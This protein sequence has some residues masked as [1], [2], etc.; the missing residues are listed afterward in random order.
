[1]AQQK[2]ITLPSTQNIQLREPNLKDGLLVHQLIERC[3]PLDPNSSYCNFLQSGHFSET[4]AAAEKEGQLVG[5]T[6]GYLLPNQP[7]TL[8]FWQVAVD[9]S[10]RGLGLASTMI[11][12]ILARPVCENVRHIH[13][14]ITKDNQASWALFKRLAA[15]LD[16]DLQSSVWLDKNIHFHGQHDSEHLVHI[17]PINSKKLK[18]LS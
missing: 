17:G 11:H 8:F 6:S 1:M 16:A 18:E 15:S 4:C 5:F 10:A 9:S 3:P 13:T 12:H 7:D 2:A 14:T